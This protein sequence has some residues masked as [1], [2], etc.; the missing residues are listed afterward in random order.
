M[1]EIEALIIQGMCVGFGSAI[2][3]FLASAIVT[4]NLDKHIEKFKKEIEKEM[5][6]IREKIKNNNQK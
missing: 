4:K 3:T 6:G 2:G 1:I 5:K